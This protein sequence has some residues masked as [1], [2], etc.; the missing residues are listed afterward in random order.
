MKNKIEI[1]HCLIQEAGDIRTFEGDYP[2]ESEWINLS[3]FKEKIKE[4]RKNHSD[5][6]YGYGL[7]YT[8]ALDW[9]LS[10]LEKNK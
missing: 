2:D 7:G 10:L 5:T 6:K 3:L 4:T 9:I 1:E 8:N